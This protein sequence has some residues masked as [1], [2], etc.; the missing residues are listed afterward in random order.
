MK[1]IL[2]FVALALLT[3]LGAIVGTAY[4]SRSS[5]KAQE[6]A[7]LTAK[8]EHTSGN[9]ERLQTPQPMDDPPRVPP[10]EIVG[11]AEQHAALHAR[12]KQ[13]DEEL[14]AKAKARGWREAYV[15]AT[16]A[17]I[18]AEIKVLEDE[19]YNATK[20]EFDY[21]FSVGKYEV[22]SEDGVYRSNSLEF[23]QTAVYQVRLLPGGSVQKST[24]PREDF[25]EV[26]ELKELSAW[27]KGE[28][29]AKK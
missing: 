23:D 9:S 5:G 2:F 21:R 10:E 27:L 29:V 24:L 19:I 16:K 26:Y 12:K 17:D 15:Y 4:L 14:A 8:Q 22:L 7:L 3:V 18:E 1:P 6:P 28:M 25:P 11:A 20:E 13:I